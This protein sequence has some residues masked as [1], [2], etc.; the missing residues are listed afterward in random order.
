VTGQ[1]TSR[2]AFISYVRQDKA[3]VDRLQQTLEGAG[4]KVWRDTEKLWPGQDWKIEIGR[5]IQAGS[6]AF[7]ACLSENSTQREKTF[8]NEELILAVEEMRLRKPGAVWLLP[9][10]FDDCAIPAYDLGAG[11]TLA[12]LHSVDLFG[13]QQ[14]HGTARLVAAVLSILGLPPAPRPWWRAL[15][16]H[17]RIGS[18]AVLIVV[19]LITAGFYVAGHVAHGSFTATGSVSCESGRPV[20]GVWIAASGGQRDSGFAHLGP[21]N[22]VGPSYPIKATGTYSYQL[23]HGGSYAVHVGCGGSAGHWASKN[24]SP[25][26]S[27]PAAHLHCDDP[28]TAPVHG[29]PPQG[30][31]TA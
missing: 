25:L 1:E 6:L 19:A 17:G 28:T 26:I 4:I 22:P 14:E 11:R 30:T 9:V 23:L 12:S 2:H 18:L 13:D 27:G 8:Q 3:R 20:V 15:P 16:S 29:V 21:P 5:A 24:Y 10:R 31:C 7:I